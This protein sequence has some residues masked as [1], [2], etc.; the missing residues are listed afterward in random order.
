MQLAPTL[1]RYVVAGLCNTTFSY[2]LYAALYTFMPLQFKGRIFLALFFAS[3]VSLFSSYYF[4]RTFVWRAPL[5]RPGYIWYFTAYN[6]ISAWGCSLI[7]TDLNG[8]LGYDPRM[9][10]LLLAPCT[11]LTGFII[12]RLLFLPLQSTFKD[13]Y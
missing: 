7:L 10:Q 1:K 3:L 13:N 12:N 5:R 8:K 11:T 4:Q 9:S 6:L 2:M